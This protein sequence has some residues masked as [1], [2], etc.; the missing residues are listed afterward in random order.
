MKNSYPT[1]NTTTDITAASLS[2]ASL[3]TASLNTAL[4]TD[5]LFSQQWHLLNTTPGLFDLN[6][7][8]VWD[9]TGA[10]YTGAG[11]RVAVID[12]GLQTTHHDL[13]GNLDINSD[14]S[15]F[16]GSNDPSGVNG[17]NHGTSVAGIIGAELNGSGAV[18]VAYG[19]TLIGFRVQ[20]SGTLPSLYDQFA[21]QLTEAIKASAGLAN[22]SGGIAGQA[23]VVN[24]SNGTQIGTNF[25]DN[26]VPTPAILTALNAAIDDAAVVGRGGLGTIL[27]K[28]AGNGRNDGHDA[29]ASSWNANIHTISVAAVDQN[30]FISNYSTHGSNVLVSG[31][32][33][34]GQ[35][36]T[37]DRLGGEGYNAGAN[38]DYNFG[39]NGTSSA[40]PMV[41]GV[42]ALM[43]E[44]NDTL[45]W[46]DVQDILGASARHVGSAVGNGI[47]GSEEYAWQFNTANTWNG[48]GMHFSRDYGFGLV[49]ALAAVRMAETWNT[50]HTSANVLTSTRDL[51]DAA[52]SIDGTANGGNTGGTNGTEDYVWTEAVDIRIEHIEVAITFD[53]TWLSDMEIELV[54]ANGTTH[55]IINGIGG[56]GD[57]SGTWTF[58]TNAFWGEHSVGDWT[59][60]LTD[61]VL[62]D[63]WLI[64]DLKVIFNG[65]SASEPDRLVFTNEFSDYAGLFG[66][67]TTI[68]GGAGAGDILNAAAVSAGTTINLSTGTGTIDGVAVTVLD[69]ETVYTGDGDDTVTG[70]EEALA[71]EVI[72][73]GRG[74]DTITKASNTISSIMNTYDGGAGTD[75]FVYD[76]DTFFAPGTEINLGTQKLT[77]GG[78]DRDSLIGFENA[79]VINLHS[80]ISA[81]IVGNESVNELSAVGLGDV[82]LSG[83]GG[84]DLLFG[85]DG[86]DV[87]LGGDG[88]DELAGGDGADTLVGGKNNDTMFGDKGNDR[89]EIAFASDGKNIVSEGSGGGTDTVAFTGKTLAQLE[90]RRS[91]DLLIVESSGSAGKLT[92]ENHYSGVATE[93][94][95]F[96]EADGQLRYLK[97]GLAGTASSD[98][99]VGTSG[100]ETVTGA[101]GDDL[102]FS[103][104]GSDTLIGGT[105]DDITKGGSGNDRY[106][107]NFGSDGSDTVSEYAGGGND[108]LETTGLSEEDLV[109]RRSGNKLIAEGDDLAG[110]VTINGHFNGGTD[111]VEF[112]EIG[113]VL[114]FIKTGITGTSTDDVIVSSSA[115]DTMKGNAGTDLMYGGGGNDTLD[116]GSGNDILKGGTG[117]DVYQ[118]NFDTHGQDTIAETNGSGSDILEITGR[119]MSQLDFRRSGDA[120]VIESG[121]T[122]NRV[123][124]DGF[125]S[126][127]ATDRV[128]L[129]STTTG[130]KYLQTGLTGGGSGDVIVGSG[131]AETLVGNGG[132]DILVGKGG[133]DRLTGGTGADRFDFDAVSDSGTTGS[134]MDIILDFA[135]GTDRIDLYD[136]DAMSGVGGNQAFSFI[137]TAAHTGAGGTL[138]YFTAGSNTQIGVDVDADGISDFG[139]LLAGTHILSA[140]DFIL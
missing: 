52:E 44:A 127:T 88:A 111:R 21:S 135:A 136:I 129:L 112:L 81:S 66:H 22:S 28:S 122:S 79:M 30:G 109:M 51:I 99:L 92:I 64:T 36:V 41:S 56:D 106:V 19:S 89:Y 7:T 10:N 93:R 126:G 103:G 91:G 42:V 11:V 47:A 120:M 76:L 96:I 102:L 37:T 116:G 65:S 24:M 68:D 14:W 131:A 20:S 3:S 55:Q 134:T 84:M 15:F 83:A 140:S 117:N 121:G 133:K 100:A 94:I 62:G 110:K 95:E 75:V 115:S 25:Y 59:L 12:D 77:F 78:A 101:G 108:I 46:R 71:V 74:N 123:V 23:D 82:T 43:L 57:F 4:P 98:I 60:R 18:G 124:I 85:G 73:T 35:V 34:P 9:S 119:V 86:D 128:E 70:H 6:V 137:G 90:F 53:H 69:V 87:L 45:G 97:T 5:S 29:N 80:G 63:A 17:N 1:N 138:Q 2:T 13:D 139:I 38:P 107:Y 26:D 58:A 118:F 132:D 39:F 32:G 48:G 31:F 50:S 54:S 104:G 105:G 113:G 130:D 8:G 33:T 125:F 114:R 16:G 27:V 67:S 40:A 72:S 49:D 61:T